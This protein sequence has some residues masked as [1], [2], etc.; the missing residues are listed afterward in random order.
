M[1]TVVNYGHLALGSGLSL[2][3]IG[4]I[5]CVF[6]MITEVGNSR[7]YNRCF[8]PVTSVLGFTGAIVAVIGVITTCR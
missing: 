4:V 8:E 2:L 3:A 6:G 1:N 5:F 7:W